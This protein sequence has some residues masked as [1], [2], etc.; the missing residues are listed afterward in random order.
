[1]SSATTSSSATRTLG[2]FVLQEKLGEGGFGTVYR[3]EQRGLGRQ[4]VVKVL[5]E[6]LT[7][8][9]DSVERFTLEAR[10][11]SRFEHPYAAHVYAFGAEPDGVLWIAMELVRGTPLH[12]LLA[13]SG[14]LPLERFVP[15]MERL[16]EVVQAAHDQGIVHRDIKPSNVMV[17]THGGRLIPKL[18]DFGIAKLIELESA[19]PVA[20]DGSASLDRR[21]DWARL[22]ETQTAA[23]SLV[24]HS[25]EGGT[26][27]RDGDAESRPGASP[28][29]HAVVP[30]SEPGYVGLTRQG[31]VL[32][33]PPYMAPEQWRN[34][35]RVGPR[36]DQYALAML[37]Y[38]V[39]TGTRPYRATTR[40]ELAECHLRAELPP[41][42]AHLPVAIHAVL[43]RAAA[44]EPEQRFENL[45]DLAAALRLAIGLADEPVVLPGELR[46]VWVA[47]AP[48]PIAEAIAALAVAGSPTRV[49]DRAVSVASTVA[50]WLGVLAIA[51]RSRIGKLASA[52]D[53]LELLRL[54]RRRSLRDLEWLDLA[55]ALTRPFVDRAE[56]WPIPEQVRFFAGDA[57]AALRALL[58]GAGGAACAVTEAED[59][60]RRLAV[61]RVSQL[62]TLLGELG[63]LLDYKVAHGVP[64]GVEIWMGV[65]PDEAIPRPGARRTPAAC[66]CSTAMVRASWRCRR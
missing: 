60:E 61:G 48:R 46:A 17:M 16:C 29:D 65:R 55:A 64:E 9:R 22:G 56:L 38:E 44:K 15:L 54:L 30:T 62:A 23:E 49:A 53:E 8:R 63:W 20:P 21:S 40:A 13:S 11:A 41:L 47:D 25:G 28:V 3:A 59:P 34:S 50:H 57:V 33:S 37:A 58:S 39:L 19:R 7:K 27:G 4:A 36:S 12:Q 24:V 66:S 18:L 26:G 45:A 5:R 1:M 52:G 6:S 2:D 32:G 14:P 42:P 43:A 35:S 31:Q 10:L 51:C